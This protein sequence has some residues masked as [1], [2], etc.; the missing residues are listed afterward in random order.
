MTKNEYRSFFALCKPFI[1]F[2]FFLKQLHISNATFSRFLNYDD[3]RYD[4]FIS[5]VRLDELYREVYNSCSAI[6]DI[7]DQKVA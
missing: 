3:G 5:A 2:N 6:K 4:G 7:V 1:K